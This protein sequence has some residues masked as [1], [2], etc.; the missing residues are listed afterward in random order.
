[1]P[2]RGRG[3][4]R[5]EARATATGV[6]VVVV[7]SGTGFDE[8]T[9]PRLFDPFFTTKPQGAGTGLGLPLAREFLERFGGSIV[10]ENDPAGGACFRIHLVHAT[11]APA[12]A[13]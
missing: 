8:E 11:Q 1:M 7:D 9:L 12:A 4:I 13:A 5:I 3:T 6:E 10:A 2:E